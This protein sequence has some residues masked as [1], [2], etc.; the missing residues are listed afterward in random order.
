M[1]AKNVIQQPI[2][3]NIF[4]IRGYKVMLSSHLANLY[5]IAPKVLVQAVK[6]NQERFPRDF[7]FQLNPE[8]FLNLK[9]QF[10]TSSWGGMR[11]ARPYAFTEQG[12]AMLSSVLHSKRAV[13]MNIAIMRAFVR[14]RE[15]LLANKEL[16]QKL[17]D[18]EKH[19]GRNEIEIQAILRAIRQLM[20]SHEEKRKE[21]IGFRAVKE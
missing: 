7:M 9:S 16:N 12:V 10:V 1:S 19:V 4:F 11:R 3:D 6:R 14:L 18:L 5:G 21:P 13:L 20:A 15:V 8:E 17:Q 2:E